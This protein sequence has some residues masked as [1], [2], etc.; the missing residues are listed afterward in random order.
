MGDEPIADRCGHLAKILSPS[1]LVISIRK[2]NQFLR[3]SQRVSQSP[4]LMEGDAFILLTLDNERGHGD[5]LS[6][7]IGDLSEAVFVKGISQTD[8][9]RPSHDVWNRVR[10]VPSRQ[11]F[12][13]E[14]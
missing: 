7:P 6:R 9:I 10:G 2:K 12:W 3:T 4:T 1:E 13:P 11:F 14:C 8:P 5:S